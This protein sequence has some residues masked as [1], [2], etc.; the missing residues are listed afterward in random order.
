MGLFERFRKG[1]QKSRNALADKLASIFRG[2]KLDE[3]LFEEMEE[4]FIA[5][6]MGVE[7]A[8]ELVDRVRVA[9]RKRRI[10]NADDLPDVMVDVMRDM[11]DIGSSDMNL[12]SEGPTLVLV[13]GVNGAG[14][15][16]TIGK[17]AHYY[18][19]QG[20]KVL[21]AAG[22]TFRAAAIEQLL[23]W[24]NRV[25]VDVVRHSQ[26]ADPAAVVYD[27]IAAGKA[28][29][30]DIIICDTAGR[31]QNKSHLMAELAK[32]R[33]VAAKEMPGS[34]HE[35]LLV[36]DGTT[37]QNGLMQA[38]VFKEVVDV[39]GI[40]ITKLD[41][42]AKGGIVLPIVHEQGI[43]VKWIGLGEG[44]EDLQPFDATA[45]AEAVCRP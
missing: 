8:L 5:A 23:A 15:T 43:P 35:V 3:S 11:L 2:R 26:G 4:A 34:P 28:R 29:G 42:T 33:K 32:I 38:K 13:V 31:L 30:I 7:T 12:Q 1:L 17:L 14:K 21:L 16:T 10:E 41:G 6:D 44:V 36:L 25:G 45:Y 39:T 37:G 19:A 20:K 27:A 40:V 24:G 22:D 9:A 18:Q